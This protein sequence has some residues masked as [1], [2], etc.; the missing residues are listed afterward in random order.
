MGCDV[1]SMGCRRRRHALGSLLAMLRLSP[2][3]VSTW[4]SSKFGGS[5]SDLLGECRLPL[6]VRPAGYST[7]NCR[8]QRGG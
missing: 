6:V 1:F 4:A 2:G 5:V 3:A 7:R 8:R